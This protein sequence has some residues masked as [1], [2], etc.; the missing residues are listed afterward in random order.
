MSKCCAYSEARRLVDLL[1]CYKDFNE[2]C[3][4]GDLSLTLSLGAIRRIVDLEYSLE[5]ILESDD[6]HDEEVLILIR[7]II[8]E[9]GFKLSKDKQLTELLEKQ[10]NLLENL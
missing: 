8:D 3:G 9:L 1:E 5:R 7:S 6:T 2:Y 4:D 10:V